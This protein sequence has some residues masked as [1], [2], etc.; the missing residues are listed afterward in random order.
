MPP[1]AFLGPPAADGTRTPLPANRFGNLAVFEADGTLAH[2]I[3]LGAY[4]SGVEPFTV[5][6]GGHGG[7]GH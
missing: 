2:V 6:G 1:Y 3:Q 5:G 7:H 4:P